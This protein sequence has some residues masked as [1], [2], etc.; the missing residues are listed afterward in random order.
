MGNTVSSDFL[1]CE[2]KRVNDSGTDKPVQLS[3]EVINV[4]QT[5]N[6]VNG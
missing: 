3:R 6:R 5:E 2:I 1:F 4:V